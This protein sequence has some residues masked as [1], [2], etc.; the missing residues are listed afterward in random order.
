MT[1]HATKAGLLEDIRLQRSRLE[2]NLTSLTSEEMTR[3]GVT[4]EWSVKDIMAHLLDWEQRFLSW[5]QMGRRGETPQTPAPGLHWRQLDILNQRIYE[6]YKDIPIEEIQAKFESSY[7]EIL[8]LL[9]GLPEHELFTPGYYAWLNG[10]C[11]ADWAA[12]NT[13]NHYYWAKTQVRKWMKGDE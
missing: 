12:A 7:Q 11:L 4:G 6:Q 13:C 10:E 5:Y 3:P 8:A 2:K 1:K 9:E